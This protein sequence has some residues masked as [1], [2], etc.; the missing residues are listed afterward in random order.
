MNSQPELPVTT[1]PAQR[2]A[3]ADIG[4]VL[5]LIEAA[6]RLG[7]SQ[8]TAYRRARDGQLAGAHK[9]PSPNGEQWVVPVATVEQVAT[10]QQH[11]AAQIDPTGAAL[12]GLRDQVAE[13]ERQLANERA[14]AAQQVAMHEGYQQAVR[15]LTAAG[16]QQRAALEATQAALAVTQQALATV[17]AQI[18]AR[19][20]W[21]RVPDTGA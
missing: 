8:K 3:P 14:L 15:A 16:D 11:W 13:L 5:P 17:T 21:Q 20:W 4:T 7:W 6:R 10:Q 18:A 12:Q 2:T 1:T 19:R 9:V